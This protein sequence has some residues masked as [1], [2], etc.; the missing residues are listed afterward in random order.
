[1]K[2]TCMDI[3]LFKNDL[4]NEF[5]CNIKSVAID[6]ETMG[7]C[8]YRDRL[9]LAQFCKGDNIS[10]LVQFNCFDKSP[11]ICKL[12]MDKSIIKIFHFARFDIMMLYKYLGIM[13][14]NIYCTKIASKLVR[15]YTDK[16]SLKDL[17]KSLLNIDLAKTET[18][19][20]WGNPNLTEE[21]LKY[22]SEDVI[23]LH[24]LKEKLDTLLERESRAEICQKCFSFL[25]TRV[26]F[27]LATN[28]EYDIFKH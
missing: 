22:A 26:Y 14:E 20:D 16:H 2:G 8:P 3:K 10:Y 1:M 21:Q 12:L 6:T 5:F 17:C 28:Q 18:C 7:L 27:D 19:T 13:V 23:Y 9:C 15:T 25:P 24:K 11:N 4:P